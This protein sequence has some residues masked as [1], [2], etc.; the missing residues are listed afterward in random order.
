MSGKWIEIDKRK[1]HEAV[2]LFRAVLP[3][4]HYDR[5][6]VTEVELRDAVDKYLGVDRP[7][8]LTGLCNAIGISK[9][10]FDSY[11]QEPK[12]AGI[13]MG[14]KASIEEELEVRALQGK[15][16]V[17]M[18]TFALKNWYGWKD[19]SVTK[20]LNVNADVVVDENLGQRFMELLKQETL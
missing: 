16:N 17:G 20:S 11:C 6:K 1:K 9:G 13:L 4:K 2:P 19:E 14:A 18:T 15:Q 7:H 12:F 3:S 10:T 5:L 8:T